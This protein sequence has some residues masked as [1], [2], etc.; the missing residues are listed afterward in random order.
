MP[1]GLS[2]V[3]SGDE[4]EV[5]TRG[6]TLEEMKA[7]ALDE[8]ARYFGVDR[9]VATLVVTSSLGKPVI[10]DEAGV[11]KLYKATVRVRWAATDGATGFPAGPDNDEEND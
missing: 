4:I 7:Q 2:R 9:E 5:V 8:A 10:V 11:V 1:R 3:P 6:T